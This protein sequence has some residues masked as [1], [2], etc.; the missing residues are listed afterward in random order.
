MWTDK[1]MP[2]NTPLSINYFNLKIVALLF[3]LSNIK[4]QFISL[5]RCVRSSH[6]LPGTVLGD[7]NTVANE[8]G[9]VLFFMKLAID[10]MLEEMEW[11]LRVI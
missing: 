9:M 1:F 7:G 10:S 11:G 5:D 3:G 8:T 4:N 6:R 2:A